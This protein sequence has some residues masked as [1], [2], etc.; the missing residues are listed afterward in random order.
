MADIKRNNKQAGL[1]FFDKDTMNYFDS[2]IET[3]LYKDNTFITSERHNDSNEP[4]RFTIRKAL[5]CGKSIKTIGNFG[6]FET[7]KDAKFFR[8]QQQ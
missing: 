2:K 1:H 8:N 7:L 5:E 4:R 6:E 3:G